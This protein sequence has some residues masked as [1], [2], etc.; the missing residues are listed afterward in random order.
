MSSVLRSVHLPVNVIRSSTFS[1]LF[2]ALL[3]ALALVAACEADPPPTSIAGTLAPGTARATV[4]V[5]ATALPGAPT[6]AALPAAATRAPTF[7]APHGALVIAG[8]HLPSG[9]VTALPEFVS[10]ALFDSL[11]HLNPENGALLPGLAENWDV[12]ADGEQITFTLRDGVKWHDGTAFSA[13]DVVFTLR[14]LSDPKARIT[15]AADFGALAEVT[16]PDARTVRVRLKSPYCAALTYLGAVKILPKHRLENKSLNDVSLDDLTGTGPLMLQAWDDAGIRFKANRNYWGGEPQI[17]DWTY[18]FYADAG[19]AVQ[20]VA[21]GDADLAVDDAADATVGGQTFPANEFYALAFN[22]A[23][24]PFDDVRVRRAL[25]MALDPAPY[26]KMGDGTMLLKT[27]LLPNFWAAPSVHPP[28]FDLQGAKALL[29]EAGWNRDTDADGILDRD[30]KPFEV[31]L[32]ARA[33][34]PR[35][36]MAAQLTRE[37]LAKLGVRAVLQLDDRMLF[38]T[39]LFLHEY[40]LAIANFNIPPDPDQHFFWSSSEDEPGFGLNV[41]GFSNSAVD[42]AL[43]AGNSV[44]EC[45]PEARQRAYAPVWDQL[46]TQVPMAFLFAPPRAVRVSAPVTGIAPSSFAGAFWN[47]NAWRLAE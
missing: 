18:A 12:S 13:E 4:G 47:L 5:S 32:W 27:S 14:A 35:S 38:L 31:T 45:A 2:A 10:A 43:A 21:R 28:E 11:L 23:R 29:A 36:E 3:A 6:R 41:T 22:T 42:A 16:A 40:D 8:T 1:V 39:R 24:A 44:S 46:A 20:A 7:A 30:G 26:L 17:V 9:D 33:D 19:A 15:P 37:Q 25:A 34:D